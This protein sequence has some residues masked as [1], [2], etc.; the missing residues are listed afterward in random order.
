MSDKAILTENLTKIYGQK[1]IA[2]N[3]VNLEVDAGTVLGIL[4]QNGAGKTTLVRLLLGL[5]LP[6]A[7]RVY[8]LGQKMGPNAGAVRR[9]I[10]Y[11]PAD[12]KFPP[13]MTAID[14]LDFVGR[15]S[16]LPH[17][18]RRPRLA[19]LLRSVELL[20]SSGE[21]IQRFSTGMKSRLAIAASLINDP[22]ILIW[23]EPAQGLDP[24]ARRSTLQL[25]KSLAESKTLM[26]SS[27]NMSDI[28]EVC[29]KAIVLHEGQII[30]SGDIDE[31]K[32]S[33]KP[34]AFDLSVTGDKREVPDA[35]KAIVA[36]EEIET[37]TFNKTLL[38]LKIKAGQS[39]ATALANV[40]VTLTDHHLE[41]ADLK[42]SGQQSEQTIANL[43]QKEAGRG[44]TRARQAV[45]A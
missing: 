13:G 45:D 33:L 31:L 29:S 37:C 19:A 38:S 24:D 3:S 14:Y 10:G 12:P 28:Q 40:L 44:F 5:H 34:T 1:H 18:I 27:H 36:L 15:L 6:T 7:G 39:H 42:V 25:I 43:R 26:I 30:F 23:D 22:S 9:R 17:R 20:R 35:V 8:I 21:S 4:G 32:G 41:M 16:G 11:L 2:L